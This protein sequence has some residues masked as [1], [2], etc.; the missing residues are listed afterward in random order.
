MD[1]TSSSVKILA[2]LIGLM[3]IAA[4]GAWMLMNDTG[5]DT[6]D[7]VPVKPTVEVQR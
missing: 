7:G 1:G 5:E 6:R 2:V 4:L 3:A